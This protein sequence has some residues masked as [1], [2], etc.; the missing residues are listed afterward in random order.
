MSADTPISAKYR[1]MCRSASKMAEDTPLTQNRDS[2]I[3]KTNHKM[4]K[5]AF[6]QDSLQQNVTSSVAESVQN[7]ETRLKKVH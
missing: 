7:E 6:A 4:K 3:F 2:R 5:I 1:S